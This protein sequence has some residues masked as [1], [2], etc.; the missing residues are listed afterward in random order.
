M[1][2]LSIWGVP[3]SGKTH[4]LVNEVL[5]HLNQ[6]FL[7][8]T[9]RRDTAD[10]IRLKLEDLTGSKISKSVV[11]TIHGV[12]YNLLGGKQWADVMTP[13][14][15][16]QFNKDTGN[17]FDVSWDDSHPQGHGFV[18]GDC[19]SWLENTGT[20]QS[21]I[22]KFPG[23]R[24]LNHSPDGVREKLCIYQEW[25]ADHGI[26]DF[27]DLLIE[28]NRRGLV[29]DVDYFYVDEFQDLTKLQ[30]RIIS[31]WSNQIKNVIIAGD[32]LQSIY[33]FWGGSPDYF[34]SFSGE[35]RI[36]PTSRRLPTI[37]WDY[38]SKLA[39]INGMQTPEIQPGKHTGF[40]RRIS[41]NQY[42]QCPELLEGQPNFTVYH[43]IRSNYQAPAIAGM[44][45]RYGILWKGLNGWT[46]DEFDV[47]NAILE[48][49]TSKPQSKYSI[50]AL[51]NNYS[52][53]YFNLSGNT[54]K[55]L[56]TIDQMETSQLPGIEGNVVKPE[57]Y[58]I[59]QH[60]DPVMYMKNHSGT[61]RDKIINALAR[62][63]K[64]LS[65]SDVHTKVTT[66]H[67]SKGLEADRVFLHTGIT[68]TIKKGMRT[69]RAAE[70]R[71]FY[72]GITRA[73]QEL[74]IVKDTGYN[75]KLPV[76]GA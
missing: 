30:W 43:L 40:I 56:E 8:T 62:Y 26:A 34:N 29:P 52:A 11:N 70:A 55:M 65:F 14:H 63:N 19:Y 31:R 41:H 50:K 71:V 36:L 9:F 74:Y 33:G 20:S 23:W 22:T 27:T 61:K 75:Y 21:N 15:I 67:G 3:G 6:K 54:K 28:T 16:K 68:P 49:R 7:M 18:L 38:A 60:P 24:S 76:V 13:A 39:K 48:V 37:I 73:V 17:A 59:L 12:C 4:T 10:E 32:P 44:L 64:P 2:R 5:L 72:V 69:D 57:L 42:I 45:A 1:T 58:E 25:K 53:N 35:V 46:Q 51:V 47:F 66:I